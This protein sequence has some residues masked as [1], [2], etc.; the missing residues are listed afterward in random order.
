MQNPGAASPRDLAVALA[1]CQSPCQSTR[2]AY[3]EAARSDPWIDLLTMFAAAILAAVRLE[4]G[5]FDPAPAPAETPALVNLGKSAIYGTTFGHPVETRSA[6]PIITPIAS[7]SGRSFPASWT[8]SRAGKLLTIFMD[9][10]R[11]RLFPEPPGA[12][13]RGARTVRIRACLQAC[14]ECSS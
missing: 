9:R 7:R 6:A 10:C 12:R 8:H 13:S 11:L 2:A 14:R 1:L 3:S 4:S 5:K